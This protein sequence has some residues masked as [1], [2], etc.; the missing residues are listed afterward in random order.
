VTALK[1]DSQGRFGRV[2]YRCRWWVVAGWLLAAGALVIIARTLPPAR[3]ERAF[4]LPES[5]PYR[6][7]TEAMSKA[8]PDAG[9]LSEAAVVFE[10]R[11][12]ALAPADLAAVERVADAVARDPADPALAEDLARVTIRS[13]ADV[14]NPLA[15]NPMLSPAT[16]A[17]QATLVVAYLPASFVAE[18]ASRLVDHIRGVVGEHAADFPAGLTAHVTGS[19][20]FGHDYALAARRSHERTQFVTLAAVIVIL[21]LVYRSPVA[22]VIPLGAISVAAVAALHALTIGEQFGLHVGTGEQIFVF[23]LLYGAGIDYSLLFISRYREFLDAGLPR[24]ESAA[25]GLNATLGAILA[26]ATT[27]T[28][29]LM[30]LCFASYGLFQSAGPALGVALVTALLA[31]VTLVPALV[32]IA[33]KRMF[34]PSRRMGQI[35]RKHVWPAVARVVTRRPGLVLALTLALLAA[36]AVRGASLTWVY[37]TL[38]S[39]RGDYEAVQGIEAAKRH[40]PVGAVA[41]VGVLI[42]GGAPAPL[43]K[44]DAA[45]A[46]VTRAVAAVPDVREVLSYARPLGGSVSPAVNVLARTQGAERVANEYVA[47]DRT[48]TRLMAILDSPPL[49]LKA[50]DTVRQIRTAAEQATR[51]AGLDGRVH[52]TGAT[53]HILDVR[54]VTQR[55]F[56]IIAALALGVILL[57]VLLLLR[58]VLLSAFM[59]AG[60]VLSYLATLGLTYWVFTGLLGA[61]GLDWK[62]EVFLFVVMVAVGVDYSI[63]LAARLFQEARAGG[64]LRDAVRRA[65]VHTGPVISSCGVIMAATLGSLM[66]GDIALLEQLGFATALGM[67]IDTFVVRPLLL[68]TFSLL[69]R[70]GQRAAN[71]GAAATNPPRP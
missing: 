63:V 51:A 44:W 38:A 41:P 18:R 39:L 58:D 7:A 65:V 17:G 4:F 66:A 33:G 60:T 54:A 43:E 2:V 1:G 6:R 61:E 62:V 21:L 11:G 24:G 57:V 25:A 53:A 15:R 40:W 37:D 29:G 47:A 48:A 32:G 12:G 50:M 30:M 67:L 71:A 68:P 35:G 69:T 19:A 36:P 42:E 8:F 59:V 28:A 20:A 10:R 23:V 52:I 45:A 31:G 34:W 55:D 46:K 56:L 16:E 27:D 64:E 70:R 22:A 13:P 26:S 14:A 5:V 9:G 3:N 49:T